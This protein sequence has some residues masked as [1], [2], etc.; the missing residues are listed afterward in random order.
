MKGGLPY[1]P[2][3]LDI[4]KA[5]KAENGKDEDAPGGCHFAV[6]TK[7]ARRFSCQQVSLESLQKGRSLP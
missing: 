5:R 7:W 2:W 4:V 3:A 1:Q 6:K